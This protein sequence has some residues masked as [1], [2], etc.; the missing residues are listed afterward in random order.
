MAEVDIRINGRSY[1]LGCEDGQEGE[2]EAAGL[3]LAE[4]VD[5]L[6]RQVG[7]VGEA[8]LLMMAG[9]LLANELHRAADSGTAAPPP[10]P[11][12]EVGEAWEE[13]GRALEQLA[14]RAEALA[15]RLVPA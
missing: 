5:S 6:V 10:S 11:S 7:Q 13:V 3:L 4:R 8:R 1:R 9:M 2:V 12:E 15:E 14:E